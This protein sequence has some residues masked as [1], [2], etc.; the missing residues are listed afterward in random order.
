MRTRR[1]DASLMYVMRR[2]PV[3]LMMHHAVGA[4]TAGDSEP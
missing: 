1:V 2:L 4:A 3:D